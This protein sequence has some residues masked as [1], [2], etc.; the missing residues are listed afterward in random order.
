[1]KKKYHTKAEWKEAKKVWNRNYYLRRK[2]LMELG[3]Q[4]LKAKNAEDKN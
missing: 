4:H 2:K 1:M 3:K